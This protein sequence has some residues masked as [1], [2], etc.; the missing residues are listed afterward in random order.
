MQLPIL[1]RLDQLLRSA[2][3]DGT[4]DKRRV[5]T[6]LR[7]RLCEE[8]MK[9]TRIAV[10][11]KCGVGKTSTINAI[12][13]TDWRISHV[14]AATKRKQEYLYESDRGR[15]RITDLP[16]IGEDVDTEAASAALYMRVLQDCEVALF[17]L[18][19]DTRDMLDVQRTLRAIAARAMPDLARRIVIGLNQVD[20]VQPGSWIEEGNI[21]SPE[22]ERSIRLIIDERLRSIRKI[23]SVKRSQIIAY[24]ATRR[25]HLTHL[26]HAMMASTSG[27]AWVLDAR[28]S[29]A[30]WRQFVSPKYL[31]VGLQEKN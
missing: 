30:D 19:A 20:L 26:F 18:K 6:L 23:C 11:G 25:Y 3:D 22:Q 8:L 15:L 9:P 28:K 1:D 17:V 27:E 12:F 13:G 29:I 24:S 5:Y 4:G 7:E 31:P 21:P 2:P 14:R 10:I 16:G